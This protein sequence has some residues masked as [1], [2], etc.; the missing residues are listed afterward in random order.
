MASVIG[1]ITYAD[2]DETASDAR[3]ISIS[4][5][6]EAELADG[7]RLILLDHRGWSASGS[8]IRTH[9]SVEDVVETARVVVGPDEPFEGKTHEQMALDHWDSLARTLKLQGITLNPQE[10]EQLP[11]NVVL[12]E[13]LHE[14]TA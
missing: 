11:N 5:R 9:I 8:D 12:S 1:F 2:I 10:L 3:Q 13:R 7:R 14:W 4:A 6:L